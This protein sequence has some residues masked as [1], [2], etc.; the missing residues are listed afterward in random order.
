MVQSLS[1]ILWSSH[2]CLRRDGV[3]VNHINKQKPNEG[4]ELIVQCNGQSNPVL[5]DD[6]ITWTKQNNNTFQQTGKQLVIKNVNRLDTGNYICNAVITLLPSV[7]SATVVIGTTLV[8]VDVIYRPSVV[9]S[10][11]YNP[12]N[13]IENKTNLQLTCA[14]TES[15]PSVTSFR[16]YKDGSIISTTAI[17][18][19]PIVK[20]SNSGRY[21][22]DATNDVGSSGLSTSLILNV[23]YGVTVVS[24]S[25]Q[26]PSEGNELLITCDAQSNPAYT[27]N[28]VSWTKE[29]NTTFKRSGKHL[30]I[31]NINRFDNGTF[32]CI[33]TLTLTPSIG[34]A[35]DVQGTTNVEIDVLCKY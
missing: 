10:P 14:V 5:K 4:E 23:L 27:D 12:F 32:T 24:I 30:V 9:V 25:K 17:Y 15:K 3:I 11:Y 26:E 29:H 6:D 16:W 34:Q 2:Y 7:G 20:Q 35:V 18:T 33:V 1:T 21:T 8:E 28:D 19:I 22:C 13:V 31:N